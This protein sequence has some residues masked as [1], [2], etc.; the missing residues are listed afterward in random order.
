MSLQVENLEKN[1]AKLTI[2]VSAQEFEKALNESFQK[3]K[4]K[5]SVP[6]FRKGK[7]PRDMVEKFYGNTLYKDATDIILD[8]TYADAV[9]ESG[10]DIVSN[11]EIDIKEIGKGKDFVYTA[12][13]AVKPEV[14]LGQYKGVEV[15]RA[16]E[17]VSEE[18]IEQAL[19]KEQD[20]NAR[21]ITVDDRPVEDGDNLLI[22]FDGRIDGVSFEGGKAED[23]P[24]VIGS[25]SFIA[26]F[27]EQVKN[28][29]LGEEFDI[30]VA[31][32]ENYHAKEL[33]GKPAVFTVKIKEIK[34]KELPELDDEFASEISE[35]ETLDEY[36]ADLKNKLNEAKK[37]S[38]AYENENTVINK[39]IENTALEIPEPMVETQANKLLQNYINNI[40]SNLS[41][42]GL[43]FE[44]YMQYT[45]T[46]IEGLRE[47]MKERALKSIKTSLVLEAIVKAENIEV[48]KERVEEEIEKLAKDYKM[49]VEQFRKV[50]GDNVMENLK[51]QEAVDFIVAEA[52]L[53]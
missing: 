9:E 53:V 36:K 46:T 5:F 12:T 20:R 3:N 16:D 30:N 17:E 42:Q 24:L 40:S 6:G 11:P 26:G 25:G 28:H 15:K 7:I 4:N 48:S 19:K 31:F 32:P 45:G 27:E 29:S 43:T 13:V 14:I 2:T 21:L 37:K 44:Q 47:Q 49:E 10:L 50:N 52:K 38:A 8:K 18:D 41:G 34:K 39:V 51:L 33:A 22:D 35:F 1:M 23:Y